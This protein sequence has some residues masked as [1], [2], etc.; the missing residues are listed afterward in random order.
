MGMTDDPYETAQQAAVILQRALAVKDSA[1]LDQ[2]I[3]L[4]RQSIEAVP[5]NHPDRPMHLSNL[6]VGL[7]TRFRDRGAG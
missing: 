6:G 3:D 5:E 1:G 4:L 7:W 2:A